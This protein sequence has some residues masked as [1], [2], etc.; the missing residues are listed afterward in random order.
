M[1][2]TRNHE[3][4]GAALKE[5][6]KKKEKEERKETNQDS[7]YCSSRSSERRGKELSEK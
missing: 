6:K 3:V 7:Q 4:A 1:N 5:K 2:P